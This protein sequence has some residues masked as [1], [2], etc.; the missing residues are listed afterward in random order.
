MLIMGN[1]IS[2]KT[3]KEFSG[4]DVIAALENSK[5]GLTQVVI[6]P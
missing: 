4:A 2:D 6:L 3:R 1:T 5:L